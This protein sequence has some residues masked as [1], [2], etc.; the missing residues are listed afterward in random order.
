M[1]EKNIIANA[2]SKCVLFVRVSTNAQELESQITVVKKEATNLG[3]TDSDLILIGNKESGSKLDED[4]RQGIQE[5]YEIC[6]SQLVST[7]IVSEISR[8]SRRPEHVFK[9]RDFLLSRRIQLVVLS[10]YMRMI[11]PDG[12]LST[13]A[14]LLFGLFSTMSQ[15]EIAIRGDRFRRGKARS[16]EQGLYVG[17]WLPAGYALQE[18]KDGKRLI[19]V[20]ANSDGHKLVTTIFALYSTGKYSIG[21]LAQHLKNIGLLANNYIANYRRVSNIL[22]CKYFT[23]ENGYPEIISIDTFETCEKIRTGRYNGDVSKTSYSTKSQYLVKGLL[24]TSAG[25]VM[26]LDI[27]A[28][29]YTQTYIP[30]ES[31]RVSIKQDRLDNLIWHVVK[32]LSATPANHEETVAAMESQLEDLKGK[33]YQMKVDIDKLKNKKAKLLDLYLDGSFDKA[34]L[35]NR[36][37]TIDNEI[38][39][40]DSEYFWGWQNE[41][42]T[43][44]GRLWIVTRDGAGVTFDD[45]PLLER[46]ELV[47]NTIR[48]IR[49]GK[50]ENTKT[51]LVTIDLLDGKSLTYTMKSSRWGVR[52]FNSDGEELLINTENEVK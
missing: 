22:R 40:L 46:I 26:C 11:E 45:L 9:V 3:F 30:G 29:S 12:S 7:V 19:V 51:Y 27:N 39:R 48:E 17:G 47:R 10:P 2:K 15:N 36:Q 35:L 4:E 5:L 42:Y 41:V 1:E 44:E 50:V 37:E 25:H 34:E 8:L 32:D 31:G 18:T 43:L 33:Y 16:K 38:K 14:N 28:G 13:T 6:S 20:D 24:K 21:S 49:L 52:Y 23:G